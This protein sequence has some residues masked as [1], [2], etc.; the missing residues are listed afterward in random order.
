MQSSSASARR[1]IL[2]PVVEEVLLVGGDRP[3][4]DDAAGDEGVLVSVGGRRHSVVHRKRPHLSGAAPTDEPSGVIRKVPL[5]PAVRILA[6]IC[7]GRCAMAHIII[8]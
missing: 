7:K 4:G 3:V 2:E 5:Q 8:V 1:S 6:G